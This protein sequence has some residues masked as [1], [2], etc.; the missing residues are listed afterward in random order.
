MER[1]YPGIQIEHAI[2]SRLNLKKAEGYTDKFD[3]FSKVDSTPFQIKSKKVKKLSF[4]K[5]VKIEFG[6]FDR[7]KKTENFVV[8]IEN[9][10]MV[11]HSVFEIDSF[12]FLV[13]YKKWN[14]LIDDD[15][16]SLLH[17]SNVFDGI[18]NDHSD[19]AIWKKR[20]SSLKKEYIKNYPAMSQYFMPRFKRDH[21]N[22]KRV[23][24]GVPMDLLK[25][26]SIKTNYNSINKTIWGNY[27]KATIFR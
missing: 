25:T 15:A 26:L 16:I 9:Y 6:G 3:A 11:N 8:I 21:K 22:Q 12:E 7:L 2:I 5:K 1:Q 27:G 24:V 20:R 23:Q 4:N 19:D 18:S 10:Q 13:D 17:K 14:A